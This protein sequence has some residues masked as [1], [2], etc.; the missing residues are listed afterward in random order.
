MT[1]R[2]V[3]KEKSLPM[4]IGLNILLPGVG[5]MYMGKWIVGIFACLVVV[6]IYASSGLLFLGPVWVGLNLIMGIDMVILSNKNK[7]KIAEATTMKCPYCA[8]SIQREAKVCRFC[9][10]KLV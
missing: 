7:K 10:A 1:K 4:A 9:H 8:E 3:V 5:Y 6:G 2:V